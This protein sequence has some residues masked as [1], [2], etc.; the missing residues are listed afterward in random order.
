MTNFKT[1]ALATFAVVSLSAG[2]AMA[3]EGSTLADTYWSSP[4]VPSAMAHAA[5]GATQLHSSSFHVNTTRYNPNQDE[6]RNGTD[7]NSE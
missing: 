1:L 4:A 6:P 3:Q 7:S 5:T 2:A